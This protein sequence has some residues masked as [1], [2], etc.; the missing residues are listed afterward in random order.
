MHPWDAAQLAPFLDWAREHS[1]LHH[2]AWHLLAHTD[3]RRGALLALRWRDI[4]LDAATVSIRRSAGVVRVK[5]EGAKVLTGPTKGNTSR[6]VSIDPASV[7]LARAHRHERAA[8]SLSLVTPAAL[9][10]ADEEGRGLH[11]E[12]FSRKFQSE[13]KRCRKVLPDL[14]EARLHDLR[15]THATILLSGGKPV[16]T[17]SARL[18]HKSAVVTMTVYAHVLPAYAHVLPGDDADAAAMFADGIEKA[19]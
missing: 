19:G 12:R 15:H 9:V 5:G 17:V 1:R 8:L 6:V 4:D 16:K 11:P 7:A 13:L 18:G 3:M 10:F 2:F 14:P